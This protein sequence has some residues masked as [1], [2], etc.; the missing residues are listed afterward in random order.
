[1]SGLEGENVHLGNLMPLA[2][3]CQAAGE[4]YDP[5]ALGPGGEVYRISDTL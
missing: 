5:A 3:R 4:S 1:M 2:G